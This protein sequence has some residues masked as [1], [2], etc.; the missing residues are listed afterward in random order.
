M[1]V[2]S[3]SL[4]RAVSGGGFNFL[5]PPLVGFWRGGGW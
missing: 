5:S 1:G 2:I 4:N 3:C